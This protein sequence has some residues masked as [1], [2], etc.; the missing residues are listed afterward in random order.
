MQE[1]LEENPF[2]QNY[3]PIW[4]IKE[5]KYFGQPPQFLHA[6]CDRLKLFLVIKRQWQ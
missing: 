5:I 2:C 3:L 6:Y 1:A 4:N